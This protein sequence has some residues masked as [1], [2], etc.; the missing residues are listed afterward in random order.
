MYD[1]KFNTEAFY[2]IHA[3]D[4]RQVTTELGAPIHE[5]SS[6]AKAIVEDLYNVILTTYAGDVIYM[7]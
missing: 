6:G 3:K 7:R 4:L 1:N 5:S 2:C